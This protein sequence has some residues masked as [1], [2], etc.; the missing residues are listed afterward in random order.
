MRS[1]PR[2]REFRASTAVDYVLAG[3]D[4]GLHRSRIVAIL[5]E[6]AAAYKVINVSEG[7]GLPDS[8]AAKPNRY[9]PSTP[10]PSRESRLLVLPLFLDRR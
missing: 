3:Y 1:K 4:R 8:L 6:P 7:P 5:A 2:A 10:R 9:S